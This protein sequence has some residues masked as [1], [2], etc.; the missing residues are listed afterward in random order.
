MK[1]LMILKNLSLI[2]RILTPTS[3][4]Q[5]SAKDKWTL[6]VTRETHF[7]FIQDISARCRCTSSAVTTN[8]ML[9]NSAKVIHLKMAN[10]HIHW[11]LPKV[12]HNKN[13]LLVKA[14]ICSKKAH[15]NTSS[16]ISSAEIELSQLVFLLW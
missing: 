10:R 3:S 12:K 8:T 1:F 4:N 2:I 14:L 16:L 9:I 11:I 5:V 13:F 6:E 15:T 7:W